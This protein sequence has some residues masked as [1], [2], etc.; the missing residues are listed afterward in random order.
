MSLS[1]SVTQ[2]VMSLTDTLN[3]VLMRLLQFLVVGSSRI[4]ET[5][6]RIGYSHEAAECFTIELR[7][8]TNLSVPLG[9]DGI[10]P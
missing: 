1:A 2:H 8:E 6:S 3:Q 4:V 7:S 5:E 10:G 9:C